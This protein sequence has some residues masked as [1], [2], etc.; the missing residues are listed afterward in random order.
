MHVPAKETRMYEER[1]RSKK[2]RKWKLT[3][4]TKNKKSSFRTAERRREV[5]VWQAMRLEK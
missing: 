1:S 3:K 2:E 4:T 5:V